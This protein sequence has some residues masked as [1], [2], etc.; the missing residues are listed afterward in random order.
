MKLQLKNGQ[1][2]IA[3]ADEAIATVDGGHDR[4]SFTGL[5]GLNATA[6]GVVNVITRVV[7]EQIT[8]QQKA[9]RCQSRRQL[10]THSLKL[11]QTAVKRQAACNTTAVGGLQL[12]PRWCHR[13][14][15]LQPMT[16]LMQPL[17]RFGDQPPSTGFGQI[18]IAVEALP[19][20]GQPFK[21]TGRQQ[22]LQRFGKLLLQKT[23]E[24]LLTP[25]QIGTAALTFQAECLL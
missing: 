17:A 2:R 23:V 1:I 4:G 24:P 19:E 14:G 8:H 20:T 13:S 10:G 25:L 11:G 7:L 9:D 12:Q 22:V 6:G 5:E 18:R 16:Q 3:R 21:S 15:G